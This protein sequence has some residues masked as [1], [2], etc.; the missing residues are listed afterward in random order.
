MNVGNMSDAAAMLFGMASSGMRMKRDLCLECEPWLRFS[1]ESGLEKAL[2]LPSL[3]SSQGLR[4]LQSPHKQYLVF[5]YT[6]LFICFHQRLS[7]LMAGAVSSSSLIF[8]VPKAVIAHRWGQ[9]SLLFPSHPPAPLS[10]IFFLPSH[11]PS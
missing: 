8:L 7:I 2:R 1:L 5:C 6:G 11:L 3:P 10:Y 9:C 4:L